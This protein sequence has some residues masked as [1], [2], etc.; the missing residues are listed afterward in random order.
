MLQML[1]ERQRYQEAEQVIHRLDSVQTP[2]TPEIDKEKAQI[3]V[4]WGVF[5]RAL[6]CAGSAYNPASDDYREHVWHGQVL[7]LLARRA[8]REGHQDKLAEIARQAEKSFRRLPDRPQR[9]GVPRGVGP[10]AGGD[11]PT[12]QGPHR[13][14]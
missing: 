3:E 5:D 10:I 1:F 4:I 7:K 9:G 13:R 11:G 8:Q 12:G 14:Q 2:L 6:E